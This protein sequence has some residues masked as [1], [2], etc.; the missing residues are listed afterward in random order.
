MS[1][2][3]LMPALS[4]LLMAA[5]IL[6][7]CQPQ[8][9]T[10]EVVKT[11]IVERVVTQEVEV[12]VEVERE[13][14]TTPHPILGDLRVRQ[15]IAYCTDRASLIASVYP[16]VADQS[17]LLM[18][19]N[20]PTDHW[21]HADG[22]Q[23]YPYDPEK[24]AALL[25]EAGWTLASE[26]AAF[27]T[28]AEGEELSLKFTTTTAQFRQTW[29]AVMEQNLAGC[30]IRMLRLHAPA[31]WW[32]G[33]TTGLARRDFE[34]GAF[35]WVGEAD[36]GGVTLYACD[37]IALPSNGWEGQNYMGW[38]NETASSA[39]KAA[40]NTLD[41][42]ERIAQYAIFQQEFAKDMPSLP[43]FNRVEVLAT[44][45]DLTGFAP[46]AGEAFASY[47]I[48]EWEISGQDTLVLG[49]TQE[50]A[51]LFALVED[52]FV[53]A[54]A[55]S[56]IEG[57]W[58]NSLNYE[59]NANMYSTDK[60]TLENGGAVLETVD[61]AE[62]TTVVDV[63]G[64]VAALA[65]GVT[66]KD[67][68]GNEVEFTGGTV[69]MQQLT[70][71]WEYVD[72]ITWS[73][74]EPLK[75]ADIELAIAI[76][77]DPESG[78]TS[79]FG[80]ERTASET[81]TDTSHTW[82]GVPGYLPPIYYSIADDFPD[83]YP[84]HQVLSDGRVLADVPA[85]EWATLPEIAESPLGT[86]PYVITEWVKG[87]SMTFEA[88]PFFYLGPPKTPTIVIKFIADTNQAVAQLLTGEVDVLFGETLGAGAEVQVVRDAADEGKVAIYILPSATWEHVD[89]GLFVR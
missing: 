5:F 40:N 29:A 50:P 35:A 87:Q 26:D 28:N 68:E 52:A 55:S 66:V 38:C 25:D 54:N 24:G 12:E 63:N 23:Q 21:A 70:V 71:T 41:Q 67:A 49:Y 20:I 31:S 19:T 3:R 44:N 62:G 85:A 6:S 46:G 83:W 13:P 77:C 80:C 11:E 57:R 18:D 43:L 37:Q 82:V 8:V 89:F 14:Y 36:P 27:R 84:S 86:G 22:V 47:N 79:L 58:Q 9:Q 56:L 17:V 73:D 53:S 64:D 16:F 51:S 81:A 65:A 30:G 88:N 39:I 61:V 42:E 15:A 72:G 33:D 45:K 2:R 59:Y 32:F 75:Q 1:Q 4:F 69:P 60:P 7:A 78:A 76:N 10:V 48:Q 74:G 34:L